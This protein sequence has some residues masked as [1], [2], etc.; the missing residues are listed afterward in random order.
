MGVIER[1]FTALFGGGRNV[2]KDTAEVFYENAEAGAR[3][4]AAM[5]S[6]ALAQFGRE[7]SSPR[8]GW[9]DAFMDGVNRLP[10]PL[11]ALGTIALFVS[12]MSNPAWFAARMQ[13]IALVPEPLWWIL[14]AIISFYF[15]AR[16]QVKGQEF[17]RQIAQNLSLLPVV[18]RNLQSLNALSQGAM[19]PGKAD[20][21]T[22]AQLISQGAADDSNFA[23][24]DWRA[25]ASAGR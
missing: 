10:R 3:R 4:D 12:A 21:A 1:I 24:N 16:H 11:M 13:G 25:S 22:D 18:T 15:G 6:D 20:A 17:Q 19:M 2:V 5:R 7:F 23:L 9:F 14:G 8:Q